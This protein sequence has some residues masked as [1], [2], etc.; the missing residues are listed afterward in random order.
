MRSNA[1]KMCAVINTGTRYKHYLVINVSINF[2]EILF[3]AF[4][5]QVINAIQRKLKYLSKD[6]AKDSGHS[7]FLLIFLIR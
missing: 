1:F 2:Y 7:S 5:K 6:F 3:N 4:R